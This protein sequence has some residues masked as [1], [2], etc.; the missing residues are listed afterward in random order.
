[1]D[2]PTPLS[3]KK[4]KLIASV[5]YYFELGLGPK[6]IADDIA[7]LKSLATVDLISANLI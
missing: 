7:C 6:S 3:E 5:F 1:M 4:E 2:M